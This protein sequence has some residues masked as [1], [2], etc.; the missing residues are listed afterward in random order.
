[1]ANASTNTGYR[2]YVVQMKNNF[3]SALNANDVSI[4]LSGKKVVSNVTLSIPRGTWVSIIGPN[5]AGKTTLLKALAGLIPHLG[6]VELW[7]KSIAS[8]PQRQRAQQLAWLGQ[9]E[10]AVEDLSA[11][12]VA[13][14]GR[15][16]HQTWLA[17]PQ[18]MDYSSV[19]N[20]M[21]ATQVWELRN[22]A[23]RELSGGEKQRV[24]LA[25]VLAVQATVVLMDEPLSHL[26]PHH[27]ADW[28]KLVQSMVAQGTTVVTVLHDISMALQADALV[29][30]DKGKV[31]SYSACSDVTTLQAVTR[32]FHNKIAI[33]ACNGQRV[34]LPA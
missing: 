10:I 1:M 11:F 17:S 29:V 30:M 13:M 18:S 26:D 31:A 24:L 3:N 21:D 2:Q 14:L 5:G 9:N 25:R 4:N 33:H 28:L 27:Q 12:D 15:L 8:L 32:V 19:K 16:P 20:A 6:M 7:G 22:R 23:M 34:A